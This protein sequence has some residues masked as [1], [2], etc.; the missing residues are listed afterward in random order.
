M[1]YLPLRDSGGLAINVS[2]N[3]SLDMAVQDVL[4]GLGGVGSIDGV[5]R[6]RCMPP[7]D[8]RLSV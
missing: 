3:G 1:S 2:F 8:W 7:P 5:V 4:A 6:L